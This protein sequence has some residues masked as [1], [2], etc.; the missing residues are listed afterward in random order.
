MEQQHL[1]GR[2]AG[3][4]LDGN[5]IK[6]DKRTESIYAWSRSLRHPLMGSDIVNVQ[7]SP[8]VR[9]QNRPDGQRLRDQ[10]QHKPSD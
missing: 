4:M 3:D 8:L 10:Y 5:N 9:F 7:M 2:M 1:G 6:R